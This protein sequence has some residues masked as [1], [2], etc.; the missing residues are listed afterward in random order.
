MRLTLHNSIKKLTLEI[1]F[2]K[3][4]FGMRTDLK[5]PW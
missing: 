3:G 4:R 1:V 2:E 5:K